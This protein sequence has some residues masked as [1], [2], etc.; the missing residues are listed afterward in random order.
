LDGTPCTGDILWR[1]DE[2]PYHE[3]KAADNPANGKATPSPDGAAANPV[4]ATMAETSRMV[5]A[6]TATSTM[7][8][9]DKARALLAEMM[10]GRGLIFGPPVCKASVSPI[11]LCRR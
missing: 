11:Q 9:G 10:E 6:M 5:A 7:A 1:V 2:K 4:Q 8:S 3:I